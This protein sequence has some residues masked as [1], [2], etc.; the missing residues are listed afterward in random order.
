MN[1]CWDKLIEILIK[2]FSILGDEVEES[3]LIPNRAS[4]LDMIMQI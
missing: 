1:C 2:Y 3:L 4:I